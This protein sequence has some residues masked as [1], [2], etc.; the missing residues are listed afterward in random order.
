MTFKEDW[1]AHIWVS[2]KE[3][4][5][6]ECLNER[7]M[8]NR[9]R[10]EKSGVKGWYVCRLNAG[11]DKEI[12]LSSLSGDA[13]KRYRD[14][15]LPEYK[16]L[17]KREDPEAFRILYN[18]ASAKKRKFCDKWTEVLRFF[19]GLCGTRNIDM[20]V[21]IWNRSGKFRISRS[22]LYAV[23][24]KYIAD[25]CDRS[26]LLEKERRIPQTSI[27][28]KWADDFFDAYL[29]QPPKSV[30]SCR[31]Y[32]LGMARERGEIVNVGTFPGYSSFNRLKLTVK[33][34]I[35]DMARHGMKH[36]HDKYAPY[37]ERDYSKVIAGSAW[38]GDTRIWDVLVK[39]PGFDRPKRPCIT[40]FIDMRT[41][42]P[43]G[44]HVHHT[45]P[46][47]E[48]TLRAIKHG[49]SRY[50]IPEM[51]YLDNGREYSNTHISG[52]PRKA[53]L[54]KKGGD[55]DYETDNP[56]MWKSIS[57]VFNIQVQFAQPGNPEAKIIEGE[58]GKIKENFDKKFRAYFGGN[59]VERPEQA[60]TLKDGDYLSLSEFCAETDRYL[61]H[62]HPYMKTES[63]KHSYSSRQE[64]WD[65]L[66]G[67]R[68]EPLKSAS[69]TAL[70]ELVTLT[71]DCCIG[72]NGA[73]ISELGVTWWAEWMSGR[74]SQWITVRYDPAN[75]KRAWGYEKSGEIIGE[76]ESISKVPAMIRLL[77]EEEQEYGRELLKEGMARER[78]DAKN[79]RE[80]ISR[81]NKISEGQYLDAMELALHG[82]LKSKADGGAKITP[83]P[84]AVA[85]TKH[86]TDMEKLRKDY[87][88]GDPGILDRML[89]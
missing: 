61:L 32:A 7:T 76:M 23:R 74:K 71:K 83:A 10:M 13:V 81:R 58:F 79:M 41:G 86:D 69:Q 16:L 39:V 48:N 56:E 44:W 59:S 11:G 27:K 40:M 70:D 67:Q 50:G 42:L 6:L 53:R 73:A 43:M 82:E 28:K 66:Y 89:G 1:A 17:P 14:E 54:A 33:K 85:T 18:S 87:E 49:I 51:F 26:F 29:S 60:K 72:R 4:A 68:A 9:S 35:R 38:V 15:N 19:S 52:L 46:S 31:L 5:R 20:H 12:R 25:G 84:A 47:T 21:D 2:V 77:P 80:I 37:N 64:A 63:I 45:A 30:E 62:I 34:E 22:R 75:L 78:R 55:I 3:A 24:K 8:R 57:S 65:I 36:H 88:R